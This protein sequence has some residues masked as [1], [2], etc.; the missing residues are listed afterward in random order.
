[1]VDQETKI[2]IAREVGIHI[3]GYPPGMNW[4]QAVGTDSPALNQVAE[5]LYDLENNYAMQFGRVHLGMT[6]GREAT[7][8]FLS[9]VRVARQKIGELRSGVANPDMTYVARTAGE[10]L[11]KFLEKFSH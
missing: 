7:D 9:A 8:S 3:Y 5:I 4:F 1:M 10:Y 6:G 2:R 11:A